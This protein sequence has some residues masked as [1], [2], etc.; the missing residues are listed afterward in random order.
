MGRGPTWTAGETRQLKRLV[1]EA[2][3]PPETG[4]VAYWAKIAAALDPVEENPPRTGKAAENHA[5]REGMREAI[6]RGRR[7][8]QEDD[9]LLELCTSDCAA[10]A[11]CARRPQQSSRMHGRR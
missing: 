3:E 4:K 8:P 5:T 2:S 1:R 11:G 6:D 10:A 9:E 7:G